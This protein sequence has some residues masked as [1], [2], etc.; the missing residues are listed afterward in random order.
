VI[1]CST[2]DISPP[3]G[4]SRCPLANHL[5]KQLFLLRVAGASLAAAAAL[6]GVSGCNNDSAITVYRIPKETQPEAT[7]VQ[8]AMA[9]AGAVSVQ[10]TTPPGWETQPATGFRKGSF[11]VHGPDGQQADVS[12]ISFPQSAGGLLANINRWRDQ[13]KLAPVSDLATAASP[14]S[15]G[16]HPMYFV[17]IVSDQPM[18]PGG[19]KSHVLGGILETPGETWFFKMSGEDKLVS[20]QRETFRGFLSALQIGNVPAPAAMTA[21]GTNVPTPSPLA[22]PEKAALHYEVPPGWQEQPLT[23]MRA[24]SFKV[25]GA[26]GKE[27]DVSVVFLSGTAGGDLANVNRWR[28]QLKLGPI[29]EQT[30]A[31]SSEH[32]QANGHDFLVVDLVSAQPIGQP[33]VQTR[34]LGA[35]LNEN[36]RSWFV[37]MTGED[38]LVA[39]QKNA[40][41]G[42]LSS[43]SLP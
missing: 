3:R 38:A 36:D 23:A 17:D 11:L 29:D 5:A 16:G 35:I 40:F 8:D 6:L 27:A 10:W 34:I 32:V 18:L 41:G 1:S 12:I 33:P 15:V 25:T 9:A 28:D 37:K 7:P 24:A 42:F 20:A 39:A 14:M 2:L 31:Q 19:L 13:L 26:N 22:P 43:L 4:Y 21:E 30:L